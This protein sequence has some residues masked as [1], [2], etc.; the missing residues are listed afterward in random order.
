[1][2]GIYSFQRNDTHAGSSEEGNP[3]ES[4]IKYDTIKVGLN[5]D[6]M[7]TIEYFINNFKK[8]EFT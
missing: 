5:A 4:R 3:L 7:L 1:V 6:G 2:Y 8:L